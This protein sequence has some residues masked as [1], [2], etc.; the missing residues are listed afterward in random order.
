MNKSKRGEYG[1]QGICYYCSDL[2]II[3]ERY[4]IGC[5]KIIDKNE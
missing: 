4:A 5:T 1:L 3:L 2:S